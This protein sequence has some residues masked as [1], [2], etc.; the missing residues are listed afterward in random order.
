M[1]RK[2]AASVLCLFI[3]IAQASAY[4]E[5][6][7]VFKDISSST[8][9]LKG[10]RLI[11]A[12]HYRTV[13]V[14]V[15]QLRAE[16]SGVASRMNSADGI[17][18]VI[19]LPFPDGSWHKYTVLENSTLSPGLSQK[20]PEIRTYD[21][22]GVDDPSEFVKMDVT[23]L[24]FHAM[25]RRADK[26]VV[27][28]DPYMKNNTQYYMVYKQKDFTTNKTMRCE[29]NGQSTNVNH[30][31][32]H[33]SISAHF[34]P[35]VLKKY[36]I[37]VA[38]TAQ[39]TAFVSGSNPGTVPQALA[40]IATTMNRVN[41]VYETE[42]ASTMEV[43]AN[44]NLLIY[45]DPN[46]QPYT[47]G[48]PFAL[49]E[50]NQQ[51]ITNVIGTANYDIGHVFYQDPNGSGIAG[52]GV[53]CLED[54]KARGVTGQSMPV[55]DP[56]DIDYVAHEIGHQ[57]LATHVQNNPCN[58]EDLT[59]VEPGSGSTI[60]G[61]AGICAPNV[62]NNSDAYFNGVNLEQINFYTTFYGTCAVQIPAPE[63][64][65]IVST[66]GGA[67]VPANTPLSLEA[68]ANNG[69][70]TDP[71]LY[72]WEEIDSTPSTQPPVSSAVDGPNFRSFTPS[73]NNTRYF[74][75]LVVGQSTW[76]VT[77]SVSRTMNWRITARGN[78]PGGGSCSVFKDVTVTTD[79]NSGPFVVTY[80][81]APG[82]VWVGNTA[83]TVTWDV[84]NTSNAPVSA[85]TV[86]I[87]L[88][89]DG[90]QTY[91]TVVASALPNNGSA[92]ITVPNTPTT[93]ARVMVRS[94]AHTF[95]NVSSNSF[96]IQPGVAPPTP[97]TAA[98]NL[99]RAARNPLQTTTVF[100]YYSQ[101]TGTQGG[102]FSLVG[103]P[104]GATVTLDS[105]HGRFVVSNFS[106]AT[107]TSVKIQSTVGTN[108]SLS[109]AITVPGIL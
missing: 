2:I 99:S 93:N 46:N 68:Q 7:G 32:S 12:K 41:G 66:N 45:T 77:P 18:T 91:P 42:V 6:T 23:P 72:N 30:F 3:P 9:M 83:K 34:A 36:R 89:T 78:H 35:C 24:G 37:A 103:G 88:S 33:K 80:P 10:T 57:F 61:Y 22:Y 4:K 13:E 26:D 17:K 16:L 94:G 108:V 105:A 5:V 70:S 14:D 79:A 106:A 102:V 51:N 29:Y 20:Y 109:N 85:A 82:V 59:A 28:I 69:Q 50:E 58:R 25:V 47:N 60:M 101:L 71:V 63:A 92:V 54:E 76:E 55:G 87:L 73:T 11:H 38:A 74:P 62:Q 52:L 100:L 97:P 81:S 40:A 44:D 56:F 75:K 107:A 64:P 19:N 53:V 96:E 90:G 95:F 98:I 49:I 104:S 39:Y 8:P 27:Y 43:I 15:A 31:D 67:I 84:A 48:D 86:D 1:T 65:V 21:A